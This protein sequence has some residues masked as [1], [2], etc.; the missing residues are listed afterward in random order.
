MV[1]V[2]VQLSVNKYKSLFSR[3]LLL[4]TD[5]THFVFQLTVGVNEQAL[6][7]VIQGWWSHKKEVPFQ[8]QPGKYNILSVGQAVE[9]HFVLP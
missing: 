2:M 7:Y 9:T 4:F 8:L 3:L 5:K 1:L 6:V